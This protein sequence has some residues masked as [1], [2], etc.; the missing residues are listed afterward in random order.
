MAFEFQGGDQPALVDHQQVPQLGRAKEAWQ[1]QC[2]A[3]LMNLGVRQTVCFDQ[4]NHQIGETVHIL[5]TGD[6]GALALVGLAGGLLLARCVI[7]GL[8]ECL[9]RGMRLLLEAA[10]IQCHVVLSP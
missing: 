7:A 8:P 1:R 5:A 3:L 9:D 2:G 10:E 4:V 6:T